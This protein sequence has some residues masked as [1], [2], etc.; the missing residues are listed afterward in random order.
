MEL[1]DIKQP[2]TQWQIEAMLQDAINIAT[3]ET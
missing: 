3:S 2:V 1:S